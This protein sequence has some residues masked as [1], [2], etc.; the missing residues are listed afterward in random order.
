MY[1]DIRKYWQK[2]NEN[3]RNWWNATWLRKATAKILY[4]NM[5]TRLNMLWREDK[6]KISYLKNKSLTGT[7]WEIER[8]PPKITYKN[9][10]KHTGTLIV[11]SHVW[12]SWRSTSFCSLPMRSSSSARATDFKSTPTSTYTAPHP[13]SQMVNLAGC[14]NWR[15]ELHI[16]KSDDKTG[17]GVWLIDQSYDGALCDQMTSLPVNRK[18]GH[19]FQS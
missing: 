16:A 19:F 2:K 10:G 11:A 4:E 17:C 9:E 6:L 18:C 8:K 15:Q 12:H 13:T 7:R 14:D 1:A 3:T 5:A